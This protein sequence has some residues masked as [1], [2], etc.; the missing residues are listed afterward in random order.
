MIKIYVHLFRLS[1]NHLTLFIFFLG[2][3][4]KMVLIM[5]LAK[6]LYMISKWYKIIS[7]DIAALR[8][9][10]TFELLSDLLSMFNS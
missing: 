7:H 2:K 5:L 6:G 10:H 1:A 8:G 3:L 9:N 4:L